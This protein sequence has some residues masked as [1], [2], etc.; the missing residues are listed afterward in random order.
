M[1]I[2]GHIVSVCGVDMA[3]GV[4]V[5]EREKAVNFLTDD[6]IIEADLVVTDSFLDRGI[7]VLRV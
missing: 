3:R 4:T 7:E 1:I 6:S 2:L 5:I